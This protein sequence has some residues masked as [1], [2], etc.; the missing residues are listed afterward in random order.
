MMDWIHHFPKSRHNPI[1]Q[2]WWPLLYVQK[3]FNTYM[4]DLFSVVHDKMNTVA[5]LQP[6]F[7][8]SAFSLRVEIG[9]K[10]DP[11]QHPLCDIVI[12]Q[13]AAL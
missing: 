10:R 12:R 2:K 11:L 13:S 3:L 8:S 9:P 1:L 6:G 7:M 4:F 5:S